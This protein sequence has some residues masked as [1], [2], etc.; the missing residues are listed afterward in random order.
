ML[1]FLGDFAGGRG[2][3]TPS[4]L[5][6]ATGD[7]VAG[8]KVLSLGDPIAGPA[9]RQ[10]TTAARSRFWRP[11]PDTYSR[12]FHRSSSRSQES[13]RRRR[14]PSTL[15]VIADLTIDDAGES[16][17]RVITREGRPSMD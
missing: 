10:S 14:G 8:Q 2:I 17:F 15:Q 11:L 12:S 13:G 4:Q 9:G 3:F 1:V 5:L 16:R 6:V 7:T